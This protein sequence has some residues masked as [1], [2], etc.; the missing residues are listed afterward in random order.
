MYIDHRYEVLE[1]LGSGSWANVYKV[2]DIR[3]NNLFTLKLFQY[4]SS[5]DLYSHFSAEEMHHITK[6]EHPNLNHVVDFGHVGDHVYFISEF[7][8]GKTLANFRFTKSKI[9]QIYDIAVQTCYALNALHTQNILHKDLKLENV[10][11]RF[12]GKAITLKLIDY[13]FSKVDTTKD[14]SMVS[15]TLPYLAPEL[16]LGKPASMA[17]DFYAL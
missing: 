2:R 15:G 12:E 3:S 4:L 13:G 1:S 16:Y 7:F 5:A 11:Y 6:I 10:L 14:S 8:E 9:S 17:S